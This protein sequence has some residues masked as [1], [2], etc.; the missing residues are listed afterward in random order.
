MRTRVHCGRKQNLR[1]ARQV[2]WKRGGARDGTLP[3][4]LNSN[5]RCSNVSRNEK[6][7]MSDSHPT[8]ATAPKSGVSARRTEEAVRG[9]RAG[10][11]VC[12]NT[13]LQHKKADGGV[14]RNGGK[15]N[16][17]R[18]INDATVSNASELR[19]LALVRL[20]CLFGASPRLRDAGMIGCLVKYAA[21]DGMTLGSG[22]RHRVANA[23]VCNEKCGNDEGAHKAPYIDVGFEKYISHVFDIY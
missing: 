1:R 23:D 10:Q 21:V 11:P 17:R 12:M 22:C 6:L 20:C 5:N 18:T 14:F 9:V 19:G 7:S 4:L 15:V 2:D 8:S 3:D 13:R 16:H